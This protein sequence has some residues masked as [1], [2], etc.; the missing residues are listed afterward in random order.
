[1]IL[2]HRGNEDLQVRLDLLAIRTVSL[3]VVLATGAIHPQVLT[4]QICLSS[5]GLE[6]YQ[7]RLVLLR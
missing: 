6:A 1:V 3:A 7:D 4:P 5:R 2:V